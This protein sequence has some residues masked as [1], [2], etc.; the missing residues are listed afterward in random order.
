MSLTLAPMDNWLWYLSRSTGIVAAVLAVAALVWGLFFSARNTGT[1]M[2][3]NWWLALHNW[4]GGLTLVF[5][6]IHMLVAFANTR[7]GL[8]FV[9]LFVPSNTVGWAI[10]WGVVSFWMFVIVVL[11]SMAKIRRRLPRR[12]WHVVHLLAIP[13]TVLT[14]VHSYQAGSDS[15]SGSTN[16]MRFLAI[17]MG[18]A[19]YP[20]SIRLIGI[21]Q[22][23]RALA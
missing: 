1:R 13:A 19:V 22:R 18:V 21:A 17:L 4:L 5:I 15:I 10:G 8:R 14:V 12:A 20:V 6:G 3:P 23:R 7:T 9:D 16:F 11:P 2:K